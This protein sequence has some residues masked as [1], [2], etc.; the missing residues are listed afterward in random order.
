[1]RLM[2]IDELRD[3]SGGNVNDGTQDAWEIIDTRGPM[4]D[5]PPPATV[6][7]PDGTVFYR[8]PDGTYR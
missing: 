7:A 1:M 8:Q 5:V 6:T 2:T 3:A 4:I